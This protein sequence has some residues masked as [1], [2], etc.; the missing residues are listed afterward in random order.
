MTHG[1]LVDLEQQKYEK[2]D[3][4]LQ[5]NAILGKSLTQKTYV[6]KILAHLQLDF[7]KSKW[8]DFIPARDASNC[9]AVVFPCAFI[10]LENVLGLE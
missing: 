5:I 7:A 8:L 6:T 2:H 9:G 1:T 10:Q 3:V 4:C